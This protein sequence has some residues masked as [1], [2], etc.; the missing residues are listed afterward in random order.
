MSDVIARAEAATRNLVYISDG[1][2]P[3]ERLSAALDCIPELVAELKA[4]R[5]ELDQ[6]RE[7]LTFAD[8]IL[9]LLH[10]RGLV[11]SENNRRDVQRAAD[12]LARLRS[13]G[14]GA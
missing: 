9:S 3:S 13:R 8:S 2:R 4:A 5:A 6:L 11:D 10:Y 12:M 14:G 7:A 1:T